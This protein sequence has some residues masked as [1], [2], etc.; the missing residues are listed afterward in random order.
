MHN[1]DAILLV[2]FGGPEGPDDVMPFLRNVVRGK[3]VPDERLRE[4]AHHY[5]LFGGVSPINEQNRQLLA[6]L[7]S[8]LER[9]SINLPIYWGNRNWHPMLDETMKEMVAAGV[10][11]ALAFV[12]S[13]YSSYSGC[14]QYLED[15]ERARQVVGD[16]APVIE[17]IP[18]FY[19][20]EEFIQANLE[21]THEALGKLGCPSSEVRIAFTAHSIPLSMSEGCRYVE[22]L[23][24]VASKVASAAGIEQWQLVY[25]SRSGPPSIPWLEP[26]ICDHI[27][28]LAATGAK[29]VI[30]SPI[31]FIS[32]HLEVR[33]DLD[34]EAA[35]LCQEI[36]LNMVRAGTVGIHALFVGMIRDL[37]V[38]ILDRGS[39]SAVNESSGNATLC[40]ATCCLYTPAA[41]PGTTHSRD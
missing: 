38:E 14:R 18:V 24:E 23:T 12:T 40:S 26:D 4:V 36:G 41:R 2:S 28:S 10:R 1:F 30:V 27:R 20:R 31:G 22:Q 37:I 35:N 9:S 5:D 13:A 7:R 29:N 32:D 33:Y 11:K 21:R 17:K 8:E 16:M 39:V 3:N 34:V 25:Q 19:R 15:I 6:A